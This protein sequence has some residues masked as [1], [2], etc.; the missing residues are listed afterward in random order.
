MRKAGVIAVPKHFPGH[1][2]TNVDSHV[3]LPSVNINKAELQNFT[4]P[5]R[6]LIK[7]YPPAAMMT[8]HV[9]FPNI[10]DVPATLSP[11]FLT[12]YLRGELGF[13]GMIITDDMSMD[14]I[15]KNWG[16]AEATSKALEAGAD[17]VLFAAE[18]EVIESV[19]SEVQNTVS[20]STVAK[21]QNDVSTLRSLLNTPQ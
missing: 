15:D 6:T 9:L 10:D 5:F 18:P 14:A 17:M 1:D 21:R 8:A 11:F 2:D 19:F 20:S 16:M 4:T 7:D 12:D 3:E 13:S